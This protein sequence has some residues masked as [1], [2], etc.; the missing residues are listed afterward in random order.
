MKVMRELRSKP[1]GGNDGG[2]HVGRWKEMA[3]MDEVSLPL[4]LI[5]MGCVAMR[6]LRIGSRD[7]SIEGVLEMESKVGVAA[8]GSSGSRARADSHWCIGYFQLH[9]HTN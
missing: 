8:V 4:T 3:M 6:R 7:C 1:V 2:D 9:R 5:V